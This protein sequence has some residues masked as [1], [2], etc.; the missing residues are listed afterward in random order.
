L[1]RFISH[2]TQQIHG[3]H[4]SQ[5]KRLITEIFN[6][7]YGT[8]GPRKTSSANSLSDGFTRSSSRFPEFHAARTG[9][10]REFPALR[11][12]QDGR[13][14]AEPA[15]SSQTMFIQ[16]FGAFLAVHHGFQGGGLLPLFT[17]LRVVAHPG[18][19]IRMVCKVPLSS[20]LAFVFPPHNRIQT[21][22]HRPQ[23]TL[24]S[25]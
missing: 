9:G 1:Y 15:T 12:S 22:F 7:H 6:P 10:F 13:I 2:V 8:E 23:P 5:I 24:R 17:F 11:R 20:F 16:F 18:S 4:Q 25:F 19:A 14:A 3:S 21:G